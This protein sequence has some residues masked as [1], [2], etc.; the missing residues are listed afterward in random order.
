MSK[1]NN[2]QVLLEL[3]N[4]SDIVRRNTG[5]VP[6]QIQK[7]QVAVTEPIAKEVVQSEVTHPT[8]EAPPKKKVPKGSP[9]KSS[10]LSS[11]HFTFICNSRIIEKIKAI[12]SREG[13]SIRQVMEFF[14]NNGIDAYERKHG[15]AI[16]S[17][18][19]INELL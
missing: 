16:P 14:L 10:G 19:D 13:F 4:L 8:A 15:T 11:V 6:Q 7:S 18:K 9:D 2:H 12:S 3:P 17:S 5:A 1:T